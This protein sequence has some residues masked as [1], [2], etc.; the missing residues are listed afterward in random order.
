MVCGDREAPDGRGRAALFADD[1]V[2]FGHEAHRGLLREEFVC[3]PA[4]GGRTRSREN[5]RDVV[6]AEG[7]G[8]GE[9]GLEDGDVGS[10]RDGAK[11]ERLDFRIERVVLRRA[12][13][14]RGL[15]VARKEERRDGRV[16]GGRARELVSRGALEAGR[17]G[18]ALRSRKKLR[19]RF[20][21]REV[22]LLRG[23]AV[24]KHEV[25]V[26]GLFFGSL[27]SLRHGFQGA[28]PFGVRGGEVV[29]VARLAPA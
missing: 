28:A 27:K 11:S 25:D 13:R 5:E 14:Q 15:G 4:A 29:C 22:V 20:R 18:L 2:D 10:F 24:Q 9:D 23:G 6:A 19:K 1:F 26:P 16:H 21:F 7:E 17:E 3:R 8:V 12:N